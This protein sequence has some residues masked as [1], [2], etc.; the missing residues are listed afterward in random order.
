MKLYYVTIF[1][2][3]VLY[4]IFQIGIG[5]SREGKNILFCIGNGA[6]FQSQNLLVEGPGVGHIA[7]FEY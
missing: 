5:F 4:E 6:E 1:S 7:H 3:F 2:V